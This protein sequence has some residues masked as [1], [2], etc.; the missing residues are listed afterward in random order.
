[1]NEEEKVIAQYNEEVKTDSLYMT[2]N[3]TPDLSLN[4]NQDTSNTATNTLISEK[5]PLINLMANKKEEI[6]S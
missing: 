1:M 3:T 5:L 2:S 4:E 6:F